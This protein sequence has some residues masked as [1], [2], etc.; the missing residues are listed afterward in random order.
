MV[1]VPDIEITTYVT[2][3]NDLD[4][5]SS[6]FFSLFVFMSE[7]NEKKKIKLQLLYEN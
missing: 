6:H 5:Y 1:Y 4:N 7:E 3:L 2:I